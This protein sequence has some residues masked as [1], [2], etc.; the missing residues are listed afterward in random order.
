MNC[1]LEDFVIANGGIDSRKLIA[2]QNNIIKQCNEKLGKY[3]TD[4]FGYYTPEEIRQKLIDR[5]T[6]EELKFK[7][8]LDK[9]G[10]KYEFQKIIRKPKG[11]CYIVDF[12]IPFKNMIIEIDGC[13]HYLNEEVKLNDQ[14]RTQYLK[15]KGFKV[16]RIKNEDINRFI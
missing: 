15:S 4:F 8:E 2:R 14:F 13:H 1:D 3:K 10:V 16:I 6:P 7:K 12:Y 11:G 9:K 5:A